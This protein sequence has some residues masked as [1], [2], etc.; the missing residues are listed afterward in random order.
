MND[1]RKWPEKTVSVMSLA[2]DPQNPR[3]PTGSRKVKERDLVAQLIE[4]DKVYEL[5]QA[6]AEQGYYPTEILIGIEEQGRKII[7]EGNRRLAALKLLLSPAVAPQNLQR[8]FQRLSSQ[9][10][11]ELIGKVRCL[12]RHQGKMQPA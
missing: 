3:I 6:I 11:P 12:L 10:A 4:Y 7:I 2:L 9:I 1:Y 5:A 8:K